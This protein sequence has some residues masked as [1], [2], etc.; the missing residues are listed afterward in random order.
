M[1][2]KKVLK[3]IGILLKNINGDKKLI[4]EIGHEFTETDY[5]DF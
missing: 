3:K 1:C 2:Q 5:F 4:L